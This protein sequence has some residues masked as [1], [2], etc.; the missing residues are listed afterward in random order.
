MPIQSLLGIS[1]LI[2]LLSVT[3]V[4]AGEEKPGEAY[5]AAPVAE[6]SEAQPKAESAPEA[7]PVKQA[8]GDQAKADK[9]AE[10][11]AKKQAKAAEKEAAKAAKEEARKQ[12]EAQRAEQTQA[13]AVAQ[14]EARAAAAQAQ[15][16]KK[17]AQVSREK[18]APAK[19]KSASVHGTRAVIKSG[20]GPLSPKTRVDVIKTADG[21]ELVASRGSSWKLPVKTIRGAQVAGDLLW[22]YWFGPDGAT[23]NAALDAGSSNDALSSEINATVKSYQKAPVIQNDSYRAHYETYRDQ[24]LR[25]AR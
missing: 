7:D 12:K 14:E 4:H 16:Q 13:K 21:F 6:S 19:V 11:E 5:P 2:V 17:E 10:A 23:L 24:A 8:T 20:Q 9:K 3:T 1:F 18:P 22:L 15:A 25:E